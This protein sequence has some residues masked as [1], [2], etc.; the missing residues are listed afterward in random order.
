MVSIKTNNEY[1][2]DIKS[3]KH[4][5]VYMDYTI[6]PINQSDPNLPSFEIDKAI[7][8]PFL[9]KLFLLKF[10]GSVCTGQSIYLE[11]AYNIFYLFRP[12]QK[13]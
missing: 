8:P 11:E 12:G 5:R 1:I 9:K 3:S 2:L 13:F 6:H 7:T 4:N 10:T